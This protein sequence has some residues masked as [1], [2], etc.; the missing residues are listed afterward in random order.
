[1]KKCFFTL[2]FNLFFVSIWSQNFIQ[3]VEKQL[4]WSKKQITFQGKSN[5]TWSFE[6]ASW[7]SKTP[8]LPTCTVNIDVP[9]YGDLEVTLQNPIYEPINFT[10]IIDEKLLANEIVFKKEVN[11]SRNDFLGTVRFIPIRKTL[12]GYEKLLRFELQ[13]KLVPR[14]LPT[15]ASERGG[16][17]NNSVLRE[18]TWIKIAVENT[19][20]QRIDAKLLKDAGIDITKIDAKKIKIYGNTGGMLPELNAAFRYDDLEENPCVVIGEEDGKF[21]DADYIYFFGASADKWIFDPSTKS[22]NLAKNTYSTNSFYFIKTDGE[23]GKR[24]ATETSNLQNPT[25]TSNSFN[26]F[27]RY[28]VEKYNLLDEYNA[29]PGGGRQWFGDKF[30]PS[31]RTLKLNDFNFPNI[32]KEEQLSIKSALVLRS[33]SGGS[34]TL[35]VD[36]EDFTASIGGC[37]ACDNDSNF[38]Y[39]GN[40]NS[41]I[42]PQKDNISVNITINGGDNDME[43]YLDFVQMN[44]RRKSIFTANQMSFRDINTLGKDVVKYELSN[45]NNDLNL[46]DVSN[47]VD[48]K[49]INLALNGNNATFNSLADNTLAK[50]F[51]LFN[52]SGNLNKPSLVGKLAN[53]NLHAIS[54]IE[55]LILYPNALEK[56]A[57][58]LA[59]HRKV[60]NG[61]KV[62]PVPIDLVYNEFS[63][64]ATDPTA[65]RDFARF[66]Y[67]KSPKFKYLLLF[68]DGSFNYKNINVSA[69]EA[70][71]NFIPPYETEESLNPINSFPTDDY[72]GLLSPNEGNIESGSMDIS[73]GRITASD[74]DMAK[75]IVDKIINYDKNP[76]VMRDYRNRILFIADD[77]EYSGD[78][79]EMGFLGHSEVLSAYTEKNYKKMNIEKAYL[80]A[81]P[82][83]TTT[84]GQR[85]PATTEAINNNIFKGAL[86]LNYT[87]HGGP[88]GWAQERILNANTD[89]ANWSNFDKLP[90]FI[91]ATCSFAGYDSPSDFTAGEQILALDKGGAIALYSTVRPVYGTDND[92]LTDALFSEIYKKSGYNGFSMGEI[93]RLGKNRADANQEN[94][95]KFALLGDPSQRLMLPQYNISTTKINGKNVTSTTIDTVGALQKITVEGVITDSMGIILTNF[96]GKVYPTIY[97]KALTLKTIPIGNDNTVQNYRLQNKVLFKGA[98]SV[99]N[100]K[101]EFS[102]IIPKDINYD[103]GIGKIS[104]YATNNVNDAAGYD[105]EHLV[106]GGIYKN[107]AKDDK[108]PLVEVFMDNE[109][110]VSGGIVSTNPNVI[111]RLS[112]D[113]GINVSGNSIGHDLTA[114]LDNNTQNTF[115]LNDF[116]EATVD[117]PSKGNV[118]YP[119]F[120]LSEGTHQIRVKAWDTANNPGE[121]ITEFVV[122]ANG[123]AALEHV[124]NYP[125]P[126]TTNTNFQFRH[127]LPEINLKVMVQIFTVAGRLVKT[128]E[129]DAFSQGSVV[130]DI[131]WDG[132]DDFGSDLAKGVYI[133]KIKIRSARNANIQ[134]EGAFEKMVIL[135]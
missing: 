125:N 13:I 103:Y 85:S 62:T 2:A 47:P 79:F 11:M 70:A 134:E 135:K 45:V 124:L 63:S 76:E 87:G 78:T 104:Y 55:M 20:M 27:Q 108:G 25:Y 10:S 49:R 31:K 71:K 40:I 99:K 118:K 126:F 52:P 122:A 112:D 102:C 105:V 110:F 91:T 24:I 41:T 46:W 15:V 98:A 95:R 94:N 33:K 66:L 9:R 96:N 107:A 36:N 64:G 50:E 59:A 29:T 133:Y 117:N 32:D 77:F 88:R 43:S 8:L 57:L 3:S 106:I 130:D 75:A 16:P 56:D 21:N 121:G 51:V 113:Y 67:E 60:N 81:F 92:N 69:E 114:V 86:F 4:N 48:P 100:G 65:I 53:Q 37:G 42:M 83:L 93:L 127:H 131:N 68:G 128:I 26:D 30:L 35:S 1:M 7:S 109:E 101:F 129:T 73:V 89:V 97:D 19:G 90:L 18:G 82:Q 111:I 58:R 116:Y 123:K 54:D 5:E 61:L 17:T 115:R 74:E 39:I 120:K 22:Y 72:Y 6:G 23:N 119:L 28:E 132:K 80:S 34:Y 14:T 38:G 44:T 12:V 84:G